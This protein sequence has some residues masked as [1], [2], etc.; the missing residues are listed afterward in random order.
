MYI[1]T[2]VYNYYFHKKIIECINILSLHG[3]CTKINYVEKLSLKGQ[4]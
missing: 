4:K 1:Q 2:H 3:T